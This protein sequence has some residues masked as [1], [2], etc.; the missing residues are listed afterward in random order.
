M[1]FNDEEEDSDYDM[2]A[3]E[4][5]E[6]DVAPTGRK[7]LLAAAAASA[8]EKADRPARGKDGR[9]ETK[10]PASRNKQRVLTLSSR[11]ITQR[12]RHLLQ[13]LI[14]LMPQSK[15]DSKLDSKSKLQILNELANDNQ[16][17]NCIFFEVRK[18]RDLYMWMS[19][20]PSGPSV[21][22]HVQNVHTMDELRMTG[23]CLKGSRPIL[24]FDS[25]FDTEPQY[26]LLKELF[27]QIFGTPRTSR[28]IK[29]F[30]DHILS[31]S[32]VGD[33]IFFRNYQIV[34]KEGAQ[35]GEEETTLVEI[36]PRFSM[37]VMRIFS[38]SF[39]GATLFENSEFVSPNAVR[40]EERLAQQIKA[41]KRTMSKNA[42]EE[43]LGKPVEDPL[44]QIFV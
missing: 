14:T 3:G 18:H 26:Q 21:K 2:E 40:R 17:N 24:S 44:K 20:T 32:I 43:R 30:I 15:K 41:V 7:A 29:P 37:T 6:E 31:F 34:H 5:E 27:S 23:N 36:G 11:G 22:F 10:K 33:R 19:K 35:R 16:C 9:N 25:K 13:D 39:A 38:G 8:G 42:K 4:G 28:K 1:S 12:Y